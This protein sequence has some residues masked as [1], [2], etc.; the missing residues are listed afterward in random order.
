MLLSNWTLEVRRCKKREDEILGTLA[1]RKEADEVMIAIL[2]RKQ[3]RQ[4]ISMPPPTVKEDESLLVAIF[5]GSART[6]R[7]GGS[8]SVIIWKLP[9]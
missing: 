3:P 8:Y 9:E 1:P 6:K 4:I 7:K 5:D 2:P